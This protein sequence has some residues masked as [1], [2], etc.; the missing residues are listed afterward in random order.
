M[1]GNWER[2]GQQ[3][4]ISASSSQFILQFYIFYLQ[5]TIVTSWDVGEYQYLRTS[6]HLHPNPASSLFIDI[7]STKCVGGNNLIKILPID[8]TNISCI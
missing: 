3:I 6:T 8:L 5:P 7:D 4:Q 1:H 2:G